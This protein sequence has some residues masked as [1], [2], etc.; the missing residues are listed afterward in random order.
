MPL[1]QPKTALRSSKSKTPSTLQNPLTTQGRDSNSG[2][3]RS[4]TLMHVIRYIKTVYFR[5]W[6]R[7]WTEGAQ[8]ACPNK[9]DLDFVIFKFFKCHLLNYSQ[10]KTTLDMQI[11]KAV[12]SYD[13]QAVTRNV[14]YSCF[15]K[16]RQEQTSEFRPTISWPLEI[17]HLRISLVFWLFCS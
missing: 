3:K 5:T 13:L 16:A 11:L 2:R 7:A 14:S 1:P 15:Y 8:L 10:C 9:L 4:S 17:L 12:I 6:T